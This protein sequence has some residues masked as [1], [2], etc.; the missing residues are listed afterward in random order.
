VIPDPTALA[1][2]DT[3]KIQSVSPSGVSSALPDA[4]WSDTLSKLLQVKIIRAIE[5][6]GVVAAVTRPLEGVTVDFQ[7]LIDV[8]KFQLSLAQPPVAEIEFTAK[9]LDDKGRIV[10]TRIFLATAPAKGTDAPAAKAA[11]D[12]AFGAA[13]VDLVDWTAR[14]IDEEAQGPRAPKGAAPKKAPRG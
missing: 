4:Q 1:A 6:A 8:R 11:L 2:L 9:V 3:E 12:Q 13:A 14:T 7:L 10:N 5:D